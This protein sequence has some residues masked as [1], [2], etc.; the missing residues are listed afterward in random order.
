MRGNPKP[1]PFPR[2]TTSIRLMPSNVSTTHRYVTT[3]IEAELE[4]YSQAKLTNY[5]AGPEGRKLPA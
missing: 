3:C 4:F 5:I 2:L 1:S